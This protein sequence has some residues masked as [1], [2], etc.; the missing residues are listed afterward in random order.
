MRSQRANLPLTQVDVALKSA[1]A[2]LNLAE[3]RLKRTIIRAPRT[4][5]ILRVLTYPGEA[6]GND[7][8]LEMG[9]TRQMYAVAEVYEADAAL[10]KLG[11]TATIQVQYVRTR[12]ICPTAALLNTSF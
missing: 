6:I 1:Q 9:D 5:R 10:V 4:G 8:I 3:A 11:Q 12:A 2:N 7:G